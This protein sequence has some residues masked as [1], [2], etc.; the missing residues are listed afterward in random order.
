MMDS[1]ATGN[2]ASTGDDTA[3]KT[4]K[5]APYMEVLGFDNSVQQIRRFGDH[6]NATNIS[7]LNIHMNLVSEGQCLD[8][9]DADRTGTVLLRD[10]H[11]TYMV[12]GA[13]IDKSR[14]KKGTIARGAIKI[15]DDALSSHPLNGSI[16][17]FTSAMHAFTSV[18][19]T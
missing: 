2:C 9:A 3:I 16:C 12:T 8:D 11:D 7:Q 19:H 1:G 13:T 18:M 4:E 17:G 5:Q 14:V 10:K 15:A 6:D